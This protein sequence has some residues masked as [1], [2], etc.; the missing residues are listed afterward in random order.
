MSAAEREF[1]RSATCTVRVRHE[2]T[3]A[4]VFSGNEAAPLGSNSYC[5]RVGRESLPAVRPALGVGPHADVLDA[6]CAAV[7]EIMAVGERSW[8]C[9]RGVPCD[10][11]TW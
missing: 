10:L 4:L 2:R 6:L 7:E 5:A 8:L 9:S 1:W 11:Q 3:G